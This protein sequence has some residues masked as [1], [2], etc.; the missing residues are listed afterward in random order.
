MIPEFG[1]LALILALCLAAAQAFFGILGAQR[2]DL[3]WMSAVRPTAVVQALFTLFAFA[4]LAYAF[5]VRDRKS[6][7]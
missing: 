7:V 1:H 3:L 5:L 6:V 4:C 2:N